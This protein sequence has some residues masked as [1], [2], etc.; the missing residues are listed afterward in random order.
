MIMKSSSSLLIS[1]ASSL[2][3][4]LVAVASLLSR[5]SVLSFSSMLSLLRSLLKAVAFVF[6][7]SSPASISLSRSSIEAADAASLASSP[8]FG[9][10]MIT[11]CPARAPAASTSPLSLSAEIIFSSTVRVFSLLS[12]GSS[13]WLGCG[14][15]ND[16]SGYWSF[17]SAECLAISS[18][19]LAPSGISAPSLPLGLLLIRTP[20]S[21]AASLAFSSISLAFLAADSALDF[22]FSASICTAL[23]LALVMDSASFLCLPRLSSSPF[24]EV[25]PLVS[26]TNTVLSSPQALHCR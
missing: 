6:V 8:A 5:F 22:S 13:L 23:I 21:L 18:L 20:L 9:S 16:L 7:S 26:F 17:I 14:D 4:I 2:H 12:S 15:L 3:W 1:R 10:A 11:P 19:D 24:G 25:S